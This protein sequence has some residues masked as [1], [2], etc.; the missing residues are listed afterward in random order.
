MPASYSQITNYTNC[1]HEL[2]VGDEATTAIW[3]EFQDK[4]EKYSG[5]KNDNFAIDLSCGDGNKKNCVINNN[6]GAVWEAR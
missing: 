1:H 6:G 5:L 3:L 2:H 4:L